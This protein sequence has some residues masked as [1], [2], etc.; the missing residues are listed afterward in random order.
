MTASGSFHAGA[1]FPSFGY[2][3][4]SS[5]GRSYVP[6]LRR[7]STHQYHTFPTPPPKTPSEVGPDGL[8]ASS[9]RSDDNT[10][11]EG[12][13]T[14]SY[15]T[16]PLPWKQLCLLALLSLAEQTALNSI[17]PYLPKMVASFH[18]IPEWQN[19]LYVGLLASAFA[20]AQLAT[21]LVW[22]Y[23]SDVVGRKP[24]MLLGTALLAGCFALF[25]FCRNYG[26]LIGIHIAMGLLNGNA[27]VVPTALGELTDRSNQSKAFT[28]LPIMYSLGGISGPALGGLL[29]GYVS[30]DRYPF[31]WPNLVSAALLALSV[32]VLAIW[33]D[34]TLDS[35]NKK[36]IESVFGPLANFFRRFKRKERGRQG[37]WSSRWP[38]TAT[39]RNADGE[40]D[41]SS[42]NDDDSTGAGEGQG[43]LS[44]QHG[45]QNDGGDGKSSDEEPSAWKQLANRTTLTV[46]FTY[47]VFQVANISYNSL[48]PIYG[49]AKPP[50][51]RDLGPETIG[52]SLSLT[53]LATI[54]F[55][56]VAFQPL[57]AKIGN[58][59]MYRFAL[60]G[61]AISMALMP[62]VGY[63]DDEP[64][65][66]LGTGKAWVYAELALILLL[67][68]ACAV[69]GLSSVMLLVSPF[70]A[71]A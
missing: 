69:G 1:P 4:E 53:G 27:A 20:M 48:Y 26:Q 23:M 40:D 6:G 51:G 70:L 62:F 19:G 11:D 3:R 44:S 67:K 59:G 55:Q 42:E 38:T 7:Q 16:T 13:D 2:R 57:K 71:V 49:A 31:L 39:V 14:S 28:W 10:T 33:F 22:G 36:P 9:S 61:L 17:S 66:G 25:G 32:V 47:L 52:L 60:L 54:V 29:V 41:A 30:R 8:G 35:E 50:T 46:L 24:T 64:L 21:N 65:F 43:L 12:S 68:N 56:V 5:G 58:I 45:H 15:H 63:L 37:S 34:E 18:E